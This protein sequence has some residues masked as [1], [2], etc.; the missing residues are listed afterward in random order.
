MASKV[1]FK[2][3]RLYDYQ[4]NLNFNDLDFLKTKLTNLHTNWDV[5]SCYIKITQKGN[6]LIVQG[7]VKLYK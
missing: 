6:M 3:L 5:Y 4:Y 7:H 2:W 1:W